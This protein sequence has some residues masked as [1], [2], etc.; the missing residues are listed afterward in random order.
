MADPPTHA[1]ERAYQSLALAKWGRSWQDKYETALCARKVHAFGFQGSDG[2][3]R[4]EPDLFRVTFGNSGVNCLD[5]IR[6]FDYCL[7]GVLNGVL[8]L[9]SPPLEIGVELH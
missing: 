7:Y 5:Y 8:N 3:S 6:A 2:D 9:F 4:R 1:H